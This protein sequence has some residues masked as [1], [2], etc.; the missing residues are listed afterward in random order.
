[1]RDL[2]ENPEVEGPEQTCFGKSKLPW[3]ECLLGP[4]HQIL[5]GMIISC[6][7]KLNLQHN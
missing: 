7:S 3:D 2:D 4:K 1:M 5:T 6:K